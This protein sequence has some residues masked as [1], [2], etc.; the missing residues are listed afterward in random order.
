VLDVPGADVVACHDAFAAAGARPLVALD[1]LDARLEAADR[2]LFVAYDELDTVVT[3][4]VDALRAVLG[5][6]VGFWVQ[7]SRRWSRL[8]AKLFL[9]TDF[10]RRFGEAAGA[11][12]VKLAANRVQLEW[13]DR[14]LYGALIK[15]FANADARL[16]EYVRSSGVPLDS[17]DGPFGLLPRLSAGEEA[18]PFVE[19]LV[20]RFMGAGHRKGKSYTWILD[21]LRDGNRKLS[22]RSLVRLV[23][24]AA[25][26][27]LDRPRAQGVNLL[28]PTSLRSALDRVSEVHVEGAK[29]DV[30]WLH[31][32][33]ERLR[34]SREV[35]WIRRDLERLLARRFDEGWGGAPAEVHPP[36]A[37]P[38]ELVDHLLELGIFRERTEEKCDVPDLYLKGLGLV[39]RGGVGRR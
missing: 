31:G 4:G 26:V 11:D 14:N 16:A 20:G 13:S 5:G 21:H 38:R 19:R 1:R 3:S 23:E 35:P 9:R 36:A 39:R 15:H 12:V 18:Q 24:E 29:G 25:A 8:R 32:L 34:E 10:Y 37:N 17:S 7:Y 28:H 6:L 33:R 30:P 2:W 22:P 27:E